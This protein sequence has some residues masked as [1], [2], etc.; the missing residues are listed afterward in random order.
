MGEGCETY[1]ID[2]VVYLKIGP[3]GLVDPTSAVLAP[4]IISEG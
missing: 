2:T 4:P 3:I 1:L